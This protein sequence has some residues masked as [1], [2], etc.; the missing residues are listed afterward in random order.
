M[1]VALLLAF[2][3]ALT[4]LA[5]VILAVGTVI[6]AIR[7]RVTGSSFISIIWILLLCRRLLLPST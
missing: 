6:L 7:G 5:A 4:L 3:F 2:G 1:T